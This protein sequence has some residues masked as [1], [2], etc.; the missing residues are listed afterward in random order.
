MLSKFIRGCFLLGLWLAVLLEWLRLV[1]EEW[2]RVPRVA[3]VVGVL[4]DALDFYDI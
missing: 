4:E 1:E 2:G 3:V